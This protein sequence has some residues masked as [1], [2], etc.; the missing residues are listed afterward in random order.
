MRITRE[1]LLKL[2]QESVT[3]RVRT[4]RGIVSAYVAGSLLT[5]EPL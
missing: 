1:T 2:A 4:N 5:Q 3:E